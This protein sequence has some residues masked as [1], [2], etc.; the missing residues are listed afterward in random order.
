MK[1]LAVITTKIMGEKLL[2]V[3][4]L[5]VATK[6]EISLAVNDNLKT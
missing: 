5:Q 4:K 2:E 3:P 6:L 1:K